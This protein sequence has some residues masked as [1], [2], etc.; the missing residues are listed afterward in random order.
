MV[1]VARQ[2]LDHSKTEDWTFNC[3]VQN[4]EAD[5]ARVQITVCHGRDC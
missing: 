2:F 1:T 5:Q 4:V 3:V